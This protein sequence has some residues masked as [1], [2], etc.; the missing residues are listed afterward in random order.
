MFFLLL[1]FV[2]DYIFRHRSIP[3]LTERFELFVCQK[4]IC[5]AYTELNDPAVQ[6]D[7]FQQQAKASRTDTNQISSYKI[8]ASKV[9]ILG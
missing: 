7:C 1:I 4:E 9:F 3:G 8:I 6:R 5:N 2:A